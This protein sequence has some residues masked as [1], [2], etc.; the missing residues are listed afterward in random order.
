MRKGIEGITDLIFMEDPLEKADVILVP[1][2]SHKELMER[3]AELYHKGYANYILPSGSYN[4]KIP[5]FESE[6][7]FLKEIAIKL[8]VPESAILKE[9]HATNTF[10]NGEYSYEVLLENEIS[11]KKVILVCKNYHSRRAF[12][13]YKIHF[14]DDVIFIVQPIV[15]GK[16]ISKHNWY[17]DKNKTSIVMNEVLKIGT[18]FEKHLPSLS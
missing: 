16:N 3:A 9:N 5:E 6:F 4:K 15:D 1:G 13:T 12:M 8:G 14:P 18:Y 11:L 2:G 7:D 10:E 17:H